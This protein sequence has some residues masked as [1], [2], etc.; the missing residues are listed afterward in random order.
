MVRLD[1]DLIMLDANGE[2]TLRAMLQPNYQTNTLQLAR[3]TP[4]TQ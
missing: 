1:L 4:A 2:F 3:T